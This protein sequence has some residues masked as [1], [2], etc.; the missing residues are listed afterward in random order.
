MNEEQSVLNFFAQT[1]NLALTLSVAEQ[2]DEIRQALN[3]LYWRELLPHINTLIL[4]YS[5]NWPCTL[6]EDRNSPDNLVGLHCSA[7]TD[8]ATFLRLMLEQQYQGGAWK[9][10]FGL[11]WNSSP[12]PEQL[13][14]PAVVKLK[15]A[16]QE[17]GYKNNANFLGWQWTSFHPRRKDFLLQFSR[18]PDAVLDETM[19]LLKKF[20]SEFGLQAALANTALQTI[21][22]SMT[23]SLDQLRSKQ[24][25]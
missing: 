8:Q 7:I 1:E 13:A 25:D 20:M 16:L 12:T 21:P 2:T 18:Q 22:R 15:Q 11:M 19:T 4:D 10:Y 17:A 3:N 23:I 24:P 9:I 6:T 5:L 14:L